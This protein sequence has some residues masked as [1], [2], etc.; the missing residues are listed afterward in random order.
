MK[1]PTVEQLQA[2]TEQW[3]DAN[4]F[5][6]LQSVQKVFDQRLKKASET[7]EIRQVVD[8]LV[9]QITQGELG[10]DPT[11]V[12]QVVNNLASQVMAKDQQTKNAIKAQVC[13]VIAGQYIVTLNDELGNALENLGLE[14]PW[15]VRKQASGLYRTDNQVIPLA[16]RMLDGLRQSELYGYEDF[17]EPDH[18][19]SCTSPI[20][21][22][23]MEKN[24]S[25]EDEV[26]NNRY[27]EKLD[28]KLAKY[29]DEL[30]ERL[31]N[32]RDNFNQN[33]A[34]YLPPE[35]TLPDTAT[36]KSSVLRELERLVDNQN[37][38]SLVDIEKAVMQKTTG[39]IRQFLDQDLSQFT[40]FEESD[41]ARAFR[42][43]FDYE[44]KEVFK[45]FNR[46]EN[47]ERLLS[48][49]YDVAFSGT[50]DK[51]VKHLEAL[52]D[53]GE[54]M[55]SGVARVTS[56]NSARVLFS[57]D[58]LDAKSAREMAE[59][60]VNEESYGALRATLNA[61]EAKGEQIDKASWSYM[62]KRAL[63]GNDPSIIRQCLQI[64]NGS[65]RPWLEDA[66]QNDPVLMHDLLMTSI[67]TDK[68][69]GKMRSNKGRLQMLLDSEVNV[70]VDVKNTYGKT[71]LIG[72]AS[73]EGFESAVNQLIEAG[74]DGN[75][76]LMVAIEDGDK[77][78]VDNLIQAGV[79]IDATDNRG[80][81]ALMWASWLG[82]E[83]IAEKLIQAGAD[84]NKRDHSGRI[85]GKTALDYA[86]ESRY[87]TNLLNV[88]R[89]QRAKRSMQT[90]VNR[91]ARF[92][93]Q[94]SE[95]ATSCSSTRRL[96]R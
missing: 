16:I 43:Y 37:A 24:E 80:K 74:A 52:K 1:T 89:Q 68:R 41:F 83:I 42:Y 7:A 62:A 18:E 23:L 36:L 88:E 64:K 53:K 90:Y 65:Q 54:T 29:V 60:A 69:Y 19:Y 92:L 82:R 79:D 39:L 96:R 56:T 70:N 91:I 11:E 50:E 94:C 44:I 86:K 87:I 85:L 35:V 32:F 31:T 27:N 15:S 38:K 48:V 2:W 9:N 40:Q 61:I 66:N 34:D 28:K 49:C 25:P 22:I 20:S 78:L 93:V 10:Q 55:I 72:A 84:I 57:V 30:A 3:E 17:S 47:A 75:T 26:T 8:D 6:Y 95:A 76:A 81:T 77:L 12:E 46:E 14:P 58:D 21:R 51:A 67:F 13:E 71:A 63:E 5:L 59:I 4:I 45:Q 73:H 33:W